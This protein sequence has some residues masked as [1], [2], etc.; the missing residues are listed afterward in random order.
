MFRGC[1]TPL[2]GDVKRSGRFHGG[3]GLG[4]LHKAEAT[5]CKLKFAVEPVKQSSL[6][7]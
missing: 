7:R 1:D 5:S 4:G 2:V 3:F 6:G